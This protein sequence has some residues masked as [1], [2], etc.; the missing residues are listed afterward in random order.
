MMDIEDYETKIDQLKEELDKLHEENYTLREELKGDYDYHKKY[1]VVHNHLKCFDNDEE[2]IQ[3]SYIC[4]N[5]LCRT[6]VEVETGNEETNIK[7][8]EL[9]CNLLNLEYF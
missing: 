8:S 7:I 3:V 2:F 5:N 9:I 4:D 1:N 6:I